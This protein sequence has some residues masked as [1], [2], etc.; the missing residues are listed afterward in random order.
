MHNKFLLLVLSG[1]FIAIINAFV[2]ITPA[3]GDIQERTVFLRNQYEEGSLSFHDYLIYRGYLYFAP[4]RLLEVYPEGVNALSGHCGTNVIMEIMNNWNVLTPGEQKEFSAFFTRPYPRPPNSVLTP[5]G[6]FKIHYYT[7]GSDAVPAEDKNSNGIP[8]FI[9]AIV[10]ASDRSLQIFRR[11]G[12][13]DPL[14]DSGT[15]G[16]EFDIYVV[17]LTP[18]NR[19]GETYLPPDVYMLIDNDFSSNIYST[20]GAD[21]ARVTLAHELHHAVQFAYRFADSDIFFHEATSTYMEDVVYDSIDDYLQYL[22]DFFKHPEVSFN[23]QDAWHEYGLAIWNHF[24]G[25]KF[26]DSVLLKTWEGIGKGQRA[27]DALDTSLKTKN[28][29]FATA[30]GEFYA[31]NYFTGRRA[32]T[33]NYYNEGNLYP[34]LTAIDTLFLTKDTTITVQNKYLTAQYVN[35][36][37]IIPATYTFRVSS[38]NGLDIWAN[39]IIYG[40]AGQSAS[41]YNFTPEG[42]N[43]TR[44]IKN[45]ALQASMLYIPVS[46]ARTDNIVEGTKGKY[47]IQLSVSFTPLEKYDTDRLM[48]NYP[49]PFIINEHDNTIIPFSL[50]KEGDVVIYLFSSGG[51][52]VKKMPLGFKR[53]GFHP[54]DLQWDGTDD[55]GNKVGSG[56]YICQ[57]KINKKT[58]SQKIAVIRR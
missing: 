47:P 5:S 11:M 51:R 39:N 17:D 55:N 21:G 58:T 4:Q 16:P 54:A 35:L 41:I 2:S 50:A 13:R 34:T 56:I 32:D 43:A 29:D 19:Y 15:D 6:F 40:S 31:W 45:E 28:S 7:T 30:L 18:L 46:I 37:G 49:N 12:Y 27:L 25:K 38:E 24:L 23:K 20:K 3:S 8:D 53:T 42:I 14:R 36:G 48:V 57:M 1:L 33:V 10:E 9:D 44:T 52:L 22:P 26:D